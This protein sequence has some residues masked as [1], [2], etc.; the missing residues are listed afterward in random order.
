VQVFRLRLRSLELSGSKSFETNFLFLRIVI[1][2][3]NQSDALREEKM[4]GQQPQQLSNVGESAFRGLTTDE[5]KDRF[6]VPQTEA[7]Q[8]SLCAH[9]KL[10]GNARVQL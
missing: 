1:T 3:Q 9:M 10:Q 4:R 2:T 6:I 7:T 8:P 5:V